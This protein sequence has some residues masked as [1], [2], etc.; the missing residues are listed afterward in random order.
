MA[1]RG[2]FMRGLG[3]G[4]GRGG[5]LK[6]SEPGGLGG[7]AGGIWRALGGR[8]RAV[9]ELARTAHLDPGSALAALTELEIDGW[10]MQDGGMRYRRGA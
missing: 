8:A 5:G 1:A 9:D 7:A 4:D 6:R 3:V 2:G 10:A